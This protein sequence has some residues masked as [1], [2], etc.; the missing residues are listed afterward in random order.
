MTNYPAGN[1]K[2]KPIPIPTLP[3][4]YTGKLPFLIGSVIRKW[5]P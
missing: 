3:Y 5:A 1:V 2:R 4:D